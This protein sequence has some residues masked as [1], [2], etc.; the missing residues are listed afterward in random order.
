MKCVNTYLASQY[1]DSID[2]GEKDF[3]ILEIDCV[4]KIKDIIELENHLPASFDLLFAEILMTYEEEIEYFHGEDGLEATV[5][6]GEYYKYHIE[7]KELYDYPNYGSAYIEYMDK[8]YFME[9][10]VESHMFECYDIKE[11]R[12]FANALHKLPTP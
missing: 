8:K 9:N 7:D 12:Q 5:H 6:I 2:E 4:A 3:H 11:L 10:I 1:L